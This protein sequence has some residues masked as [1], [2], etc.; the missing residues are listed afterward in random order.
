MNFF[1]SFDM[2]LRISKDKYKIIKDNCEKCNHPELTSISGQLYC[3]ECDMEESSYKG[4]PARSWKF[5]PKTKPKKTLF[6]KPSILK[7]EP[8][9]SKLS[10]VANAS[11]DAVSINSKSNPEHVDHESVA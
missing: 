1:V 9:T 2:S 8:K 7:T 5:D 6:K 3:T 10:K 4:M 11:C